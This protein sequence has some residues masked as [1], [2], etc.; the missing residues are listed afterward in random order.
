M[1]CGFSL[2]AGTASGGFAP[3]RSLIDFSSSPSFVLGTK[4]CARCH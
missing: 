1:V 4:I 3:D 2:G